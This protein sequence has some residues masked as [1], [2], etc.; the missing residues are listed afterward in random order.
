MASDLGM[1]AEDLGR[2]ETCPGAPGWPY[3]LLAPPPHETL[4]R[5]PRNLPHSSFLDGTHSDLPFGKAFPTVIKNHVAA[6]SMPVLSICMSAPQDTAQSWHVPPGRHSTVR[7]GNEG[8]RW[9]SMAQS[10]K[11][12]R[13]LWVPPTNTDWT[14]LEDAALVERLQG[15][16]HQGD[17]LREAL[18][19]LPS[20]PCGPWG[21][22]RPHTRQVKGEEERVSDADGTALGEARES[23]ATQIPR[24]VLLNWGWC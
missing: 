5:D 9:H 20:P 17:T 12:G 3:C 8:A 15:R 10:T 23:P 7:P 2:D 21:S 4:L 22:G 11:F 6:C 13:W 16:D 1:R 14:Q 19:L 18:L 24:P